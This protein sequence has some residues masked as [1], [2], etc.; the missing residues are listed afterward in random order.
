VTNHLAAARRD[1]RRIV[2]DRLRAMTASEEEFREE[3]RTV[4]GIDTA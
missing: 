3:V 2:L 4:L 1:F